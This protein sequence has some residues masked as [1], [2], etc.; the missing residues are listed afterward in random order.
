MLT[1]NDIITYEHKNEHDLEHDLAHKRDFS[2]PKIYNAN[3][4]LKKRWYVYYSFRNP[5]TG[6]LIRMKNIYGRANT[7]KTKE[8]RLSA[9]S[10]YRR[11]L[12][13]LLKEGYNPYINNTDFYKAKL[14]A[15][16][17]S[18]KPIETPNQEAVLVDKTTSNQRVEV[19][20]AK[21]MPLQEAF[22]FS[23]KI[24]KNQINE[25]SLQDYE[26]ASKAF[27]RWV[28]KNHPEIKTVE[29]LNKK[30][31]LDYLNSVLIR[32]SSRN[33]NNYRL[34]LSSLL[35][36]M[37]DNEIIVSNP[38]KKTSALKSTPQRN[39]TYNVS[40]QEKI[41]THLEKEDPI[42]LLFI[43]FFSYS[44]MRPIEVCRLK[45]KDFDLANKTIQFKAKNS[46][47]KTK[48]IPDI[49]W[50]E[51]PDLSQLDPEDYLFTPTKIGGTWNATQKNRSNYFSKRFTRGV[52]KHFNLDKNQTMY[53]FRHTIITK[54]YRG[55]IKDSQPFA[56]KS[57]LMQI[58]G[59]TTMTALDK[60]LR[61]IDAELPN[62]Y[63]DLLA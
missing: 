59:H 47:L 53:G 2:T 27:I 21:G 35:Q 14:K 20:K 43:K 4:D 24:K 55:L 3:G 37:E 5:E 63:S 13:K 29:L 42:L 51:L 41:F 30:I 11:R 31:A 56:A 33:R 34:S 60:Y 58:T 50:K 54:L 12:L 16:N 39:R 62:D 19:E 45:I 7:F 6:K 25:R 49:L 9:L 15:Q 61:D 28:E 8:D 10:L 23:L 40:E 26:Y 36:T 52:K 17:Y 46:P 44:I 38:M 1:F 18:K 22:D 57:I 48:L 32:T